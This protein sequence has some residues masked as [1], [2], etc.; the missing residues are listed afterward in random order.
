MS[1]L[2][3]HKYVSK[4]KLECYLVFLEFEDES[5]YF[6]PLRH[7]LMT[8]IIVDNIVHTIIVLS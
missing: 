3:G 4:L 2:I 6:T 1:S 5:I 7:H 8:L